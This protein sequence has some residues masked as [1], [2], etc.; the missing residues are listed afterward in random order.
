VSLK[1]ASVLYALAIVAMPISVASKFLFGLNGVTWVDP[2]LILS[3]AAFLALAPHW[4]DFIWGE[5]RSITLGILFISGVT[6]VCACS[7][8]LLRPTSS[9]YVVF[10]EPLR[11]WL[12]LCWMLVSSWYLLHRPALV[13]RMSVVAVFFA[14]CSGVY[15]HLVV[16]GVVPAPQLIVSYMRIYFIRQLIWIH[17]VPVPRMGGLFIEA[18]PFGLFMF[19]M[20][21]VL[22]VA[23]ENGLR[24][25]WAGLGLVLAAVGTLFSIADQVFLG[26]LLW[27]VVSFSALRRRYKRLIWV[28]AI[29]AVVLGAF[30]V[31]TIFQKQINAVSGVGVDINGSSIGERAFHFNYGMSLLQAYPAAVGFGIGPGRYGEYVA[32]TGNYPS[33]VNMQTSEAEILVEWGVIGVLAWGALLALAVAQVW[34]VHRILG[35]GLLLGVIAADSFQ[36]NWKYESVFLALAALSVRKRSDLV[37]APDM[38]ED[39]LYQGPSA[40]QLTS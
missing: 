35:V 9:L 15:L 17:G 16:F 33:S 19:S 27:L 21:A 28:I 40:P 1:C 13:V 14:L 26:G 34:R 5:L 25:R 12:N 29:A 24:P 31:S 7:G 18:P 2:S 10:R 32:E 20:M 4:G 38:I 22:Y 37:D 6:L 30:E 3:F 36:A 23:R 8:L 39:A 11:L